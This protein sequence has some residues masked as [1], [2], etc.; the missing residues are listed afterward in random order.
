MCNTCVENKVEDDEFLKQ[1]PVIFS[2]QEYNSFLTG[3]YDGTITSENLPE[4]FYLKTANF[5]E[6]GLFKGLGNK[7]V[8]ASFNTPDWILTNEMRNN[9]YYFSGAKTYTE[10]RFLT[11]LVVD[12]SG[13]VVPFSQ[14]KK[15]ALRLLKDYNESYLGAERDTALASGR[16]ASDWATIQEDKTL[17]PKLQYVTVGDKRVRPTHARLDNIIKPINSPFWNIYFPP[18]GWRCRCTTIQLQ[19]DEKTTRTTKK[20]LPEIDPLFAFN[21]GKEKIVFQTK[22]ANKHP[23]FKVKRGDGDLKQRNFNFE[24]PPL[25]NG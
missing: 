24:I 10:H 12:S 25:E 22:G 8:E 14:Y 3:V 17:Y 13:N 4:N 23:Y 9:I 21:P 15:A 11:E 1:N 6:A 5:I 7:R 16:S 18:N 2:E 20:N 19:G